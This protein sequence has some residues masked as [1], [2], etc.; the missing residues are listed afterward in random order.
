MI[1]HISKPYLKRRLAEYPPP[2]VA[3]TPLIYADKLC[4][5]Y[6]SKVTKTDKKANGQFF[7]PVSIARFMA[8]FNRATNKTIRILDPG[9]GTGILSCAL[10]EHLVNTP[11]RPVSVHLDV[12]EIDGKA[13]DLLEACLGF[14]RRWLRK[15]DVQLKF[16]VIREDFVLTHADVLN[17]T[18]SLFKATW[19]DL[20]DVVISNPPYF[21]ISKKDKRAQASL[22]V[23][24]GQPNIYMLFMAISASLLRDGGYLTFITPRSFAAGPYFRRFR[25]YFFEKMCPESIHIFASRSETFV[26]D[27]ILQ[28]NAILHARRI[29]DRC[30]CVEHGEVRISQSN[31]ISDLDQCLARVVP[32]AAV[33]DRSS[34]DLVLR[35]PVEKTD[36]ATSK[37]IN[38]WQDRFLSLG[39]AVSTGPVVPFRASD[40]IRTSGNLRGSHAPLLWM[41]NTKP[42]RVD[43]PLNTR[44]EQYIT[45]SE[46][47][48]PL[49]LPNRN[50]VL[51]RRFSAKEDRR[52]LIAA[53]LLEGT[54]ASSYIGIENHLNYI[55]RPKGNLTKEEALGIAAILNSKILDEYF[56]ITS[57][58]T[59]VSATEIRR[60]PFPPVS[61]VKRIGRAISSLA[62]IEHFESVV[63]DILLSDKIR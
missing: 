1:P 53:P 56:R 38:N 48:K 50:Y 4:S 34:K 28:E 42:M 15:R 41:Q 5:W 11:D 24:H 17:P 62:H 6:D 59:Q 9:A 40:L 54:I 19:L 20:Y 49:L 21:K 13:A 61:T 22:D 52:R 29:H 60:L 16:N 39:L 23:I 33:F 46:A 32:T 43:W 3:D 55:Y 47:S 26:K 44:K 8:Q 14:A 58:N 30:K 35:I 63:S 7:T 18:S 31:G 10:L 45:I 57:G 37:L 12:F 2:S 25:Q 36:D 51:L 27:S